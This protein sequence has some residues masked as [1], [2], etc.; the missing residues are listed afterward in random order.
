MLPFLGV[1]W[2]EVKVLHESGVG[3]EHQEIFIFKQTGLAEYLYF[4]PEKPVL[5]ILWDKVIFGIN[6]L[7]KMVLLW[8]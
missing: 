3:R 8:E 7:K 2:S 6:V 5:G 1:G 4:H